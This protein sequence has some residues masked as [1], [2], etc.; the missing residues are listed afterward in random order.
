MCKPKVLQTLDLQSVGY[1]LLRLPE[2]AYTVNDVVRL[3]GVKIN[4]ICKTI[5]LIDKQNKEPLLVV[6]PGDKKVD[7]E[8]FQRFLGRSLRFARPDEIKE[9][10]GHELGALPPYGHRR[11]VAT[12]VDVNL[13]KENK[14]NFGTGVHNLGVEIKSEDLKKVV[15]FETV[16]IT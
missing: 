10:T 9:I 16:E 8:K 11:H 13:L 14:I 5:L 3:A 12:Y 7:M 6:I 2:K 15:K 1:R 4:E